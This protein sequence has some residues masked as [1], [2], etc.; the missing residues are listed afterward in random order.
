MLLLIASLSSENV[1]MLVVMISLPLLLQ[2]LKRNNAKREI[3]KGF[4]SF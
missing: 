4:I 1:A 2:L 3:R